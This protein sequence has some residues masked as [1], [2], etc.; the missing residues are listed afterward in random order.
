[1]EK[2]L[3]VVYQIRW[4]IEDVVYVGKNHQPKQFVAGLKTARI[5]PGLKMSAVMMTILHSSR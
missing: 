1:M 4:D 3:W 2:G 5:R